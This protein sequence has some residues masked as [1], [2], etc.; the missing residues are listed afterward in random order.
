MKLSD[1]AKQKISNAHKGRI[2][3]NLYSPVN[4]I[5]LKTFNI[6]NTF[7]SIKEACENTGIRSSGIQA[8]CC[9]RMKSAG[10]FKWEYVNNNDLKR[11]VRSKALIGRSVSK[12]N[13]EKISK[14][15]SKPIEQYDLNYNLIREWDSIKQIAK[16][17]NISSKWF[18]DYLNN[19][20]TK[21]NY[22]GFI[23]KRK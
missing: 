19:K 5:C 12:E 16:E 2:R 11:E 15:V 23:W 1:L 20:T 18:I 8:S 4:Q 6:L 21:T 9:G 17:L 3:E 14:S 10:G 22:N 13:R 7:K